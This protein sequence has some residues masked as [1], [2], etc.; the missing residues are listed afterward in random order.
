MSALSIALLIIGAFISTACLVGLTADAARQ[1]RL[2]AQAEHDAQI[3]RIQAL[4]ESGNQIAAQVT[5]EL[6]RGR[7]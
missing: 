2:R 6:A 5:A 4:I 1:E 7:G 3:R